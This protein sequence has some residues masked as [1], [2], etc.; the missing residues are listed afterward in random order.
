ML[1]HSPTCTPAPAAPPR[2]PSQ[3]PFSVGPSLTPDLPA[4]VRPQAL[5]SLLVGLGSLGNG[6]GS[7]RLTSTEQGLGRAGRGTAQR[8]VW[9]DPAQVLALLC[10]SRVTLTQYLIS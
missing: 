2:P 7:D 6:S 10:P 4:H 3:V 5:L 8:S 9:P 1:P